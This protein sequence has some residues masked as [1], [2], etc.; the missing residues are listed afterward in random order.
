ML[1]SHGPRPVLLCVAHLSLGGREDACAPPIAPHVLAEGGSK[2]L[3]LA[4]SLVQYCDHFQSN[5]LHLV[6]MEAVVLW[7]QTFSNS[8]W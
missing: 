1:D 8:L 3:S 6:T 5:E 4:T 7:L 2:V